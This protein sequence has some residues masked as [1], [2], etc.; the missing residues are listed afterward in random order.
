MR[1]AGV[2]QAAAYASSA[3]LVGAAP[4]QLS[5]RDDGHLYQ[6]KPGEISTPRCG[7]FAKDQGWG[8]ASVPWITDVS[9]AGDSFCATR[10]QSGQVIRGLAAFKE[11]WDGKCDGKGAISRLE[12]RYSGGEVDVLGNGNKACPAG[13]FAP[14]MD[15]VITSI[16]SYRAGDRPDAQ[17]RI[18]FNTK[19][20]GK[21][22]LAKLKDEWAPDDGTKYSPGVQGGI[23]TGLTGYITN[24]VITE[25]DFHFIPG[26]LINANTDNFQYDQD[27]LKQ[28]KLTTKVVAT[29]SFIN[30]DPDH[31]ANYS[32]SSSSTT[33]HSVHTESEHTKTMGASVSMTESVGVPNIGISSTQE[34]HWDDTTRDLKSESN[35]TETS[36]SW[37]MSGVVGPLKATDCKIYTGTVS[38]TIPYKATVRLQFTNDQHYWY[39]TTGKVDAKNLVGTAGI[40]DCTPR[41]IK[42]GEKTSD[43]SVLTLHPELSKNSTSAA[44]SSIASSASSVTLPASSSTAAATSNASQTQDAPETT[45]AA[46]TSSAEKKTSSAIKK[47]SSSTTEDAPEETE[48]PEAP[49]TTSSSKKASVSAKKTSSIVTDDAPEITDAPETTSSSKKASSTAKKTSSTTSDDAPEETET[50]DTPETTSSTKKASVTAKKTSNTTSDDAPE[51]TDAPVT[52]SSTKKASVTAKK[53]SSTTSDDAPEET[54]APTTSD[55]PEKK[56]PG[57]A[58]KS[59]STANDAVTTSSSLKSTPTTLKTTSKATTKTPTKAT[60]TKSPSKTTI[61]KA[62]FTNA[63]G[64]K[65]TDPDEETDSTDVDETEDSS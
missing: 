52:T 18:D 27:A 50:P 24:D 64:A 36:I 37:T 17:G 15:E 23:L 42:P 32:L 65:V 25:V 5:A 10:W 54:D 61:K 12:I 63:A 26:T 43:P 14:E 33:S 62:A 41:D 1:S 51:E 30:G 48:A 47:T 56:N 8:T 22:K 16:N 35:F 60:T 58:A 34:A 59:T 2:F 21:D 11:S 20:G 45:K 44:S 19:Q 31:D 57:L 9:K 3:L 4:A 38:G 7:G 40:T 13:T 29:H 46:K 28:I 49:E 39:D 53:T 55:G 6:P